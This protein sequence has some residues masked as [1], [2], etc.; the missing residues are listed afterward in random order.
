[1]PKKPSIPLRAL[2]LLGRWTR[3][4]QGHLALGAG[5]I[6]GG[7][8][9][10]VRAQDL[11]LNVLDYLATRHSGDAA[12]GRLLSECAGYRDGTAGS[13]S[14]MLQAIARRTDVAPESAQAALLDDLE[15]TIESFDAAHRQ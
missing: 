6:C 3:V 13:L 11:E 14:N 12:I 7:M 15:R 10:G 1:M 4:S 9:V 2:Q 8:M 5:C